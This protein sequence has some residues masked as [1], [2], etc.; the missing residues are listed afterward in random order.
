MWHSY[1]WESK[2]I[3]CRLGNAQVE[4]VKETCWWPVEYDDTVLSDG[5]AKYVYQE[6]RK[7]IHCYIHSYYSVFPC[8]A[9]PNQ[10]H[11]FGYSNQVFHLI[12]LIHFALYL[13]SNLFPHLFIILCSTLFF[14]GFHFNTSQFDLSFNALLPLLIGFFKILILIS[15]TFTPFKTF[16]VWLRKAQIQI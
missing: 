7:Q 9:L 11:L 8:C 15:Q 1:S 3:K 14:W 4:S 12:R 5:K 16:T 6:N 2:V 10:L 13:I